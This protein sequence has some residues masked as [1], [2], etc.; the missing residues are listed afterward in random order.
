MD[1]EP[2]ENRPWGYFQVLADESNHK[3]KRIVIFP[4]QRLS[5]QCHSQRAEHWHII[6]GKAIVT[7][8]QDTISLSVG[9]SVDIPKGV[10]HRI[11]NPGHENLVFI[12]VQ[13]G[14]YFG[15]DDIERFEDDYGRVP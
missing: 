1:S 10:K 2:K 7:R 5:L 11:Q 9:Q 8:N 12:E 6:D 15:E 3:V 14:E 13:S 4:K